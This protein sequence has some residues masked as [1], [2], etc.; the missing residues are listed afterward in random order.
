MCLKLKHHSHRKKKL[1]KLADNY[2]ILIFKIM[3]A[4]MGAVLAGALTYFLSTTRG[5][6]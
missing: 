2:G 1:S 4:V 6:F 3:L 5:R